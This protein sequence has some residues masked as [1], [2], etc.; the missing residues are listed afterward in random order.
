M[1]KYYQSIQEEKIIMQKMTSTMKWDAIHVLE[2][3]RKLHPKDTAGDWADLFNSCLKNCDRELDLR[4]QSVDYSYVR[5][6]QFV[7]RYAVRQLQRIN[8]P[9]Y[10]HIVENHIASKLISDVLAGM[11]QDKEIIRQGL[12]VYIDFSNAEFKL[13]LNGLHNVLDSNFENVKAKE[14]YPLTY[15][16]ALGYAK[17]RFEKIIQAEYNNIDF[18]NPIPAT[19]AIEK[20]LNL[21][22]CFVEFTFDKQEKKPKF[23]KKTG[24]RLPESEWTKFAMPI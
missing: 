14:K 18:W 9:D 24:K 20:E 15:R 12:Q 3:H 4:N 6:L 1:I 22:N 7:A 16:N 13:R 19:N 5:V 11:C 17:W 2:S 21:E 8:N 23:N 10:N